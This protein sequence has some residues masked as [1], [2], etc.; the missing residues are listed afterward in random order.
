MITGSGTGPEQQ[1]YSML[2]MSM[3]EDNGY[4]NL[5]AIPEPA[6]SGVMVSWLIG[7]FSV[8]RRR[9]GNRRRG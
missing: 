4:D 1:A 8:W 6:T 7:G 9:N 5:S 2:E 3:I